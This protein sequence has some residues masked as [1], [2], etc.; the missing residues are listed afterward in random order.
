VSRSLVWSLY[1]LNVLIWSSTWVAIKI[2]LEDVPPLLSAG[3]RFAVAGAGLLALAVVLGRRLKTDWLLA[4][5][6]GLLP[7][8]GAY[9]LD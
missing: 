4:A 8:A 3:V 5:L 9:G 7:F 2:G 6:L 1:G